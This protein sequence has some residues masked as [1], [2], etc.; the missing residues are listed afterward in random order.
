MALLPLIHLKSQSTELLVCLGVDVH[1]CL[2]RVEAVSL[3]VFVWRTMFYLLS[4]LLISIL[5]MCAE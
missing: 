4:A 3:H 2:L 5:G 1:Q